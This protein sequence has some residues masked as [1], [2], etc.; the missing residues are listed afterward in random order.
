MCLWIVNWIS[1]SQRPDVAIEFYHPTKA[2]KIIIF[3][4]K[5]KLDSDGIGGD[6]SMGQPKKIDIDKMH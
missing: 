4:P 6:N 5:Y 1:F 3:D 2:R